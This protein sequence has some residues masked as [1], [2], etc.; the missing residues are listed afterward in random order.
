MQK[1]CIFFLQVTDVEL[2]AIGGYYKEN[3][4][5][6]F[7]GLATLKRD[8]G[9]MDSR[10]TEDKNEIDPQRQRSGFMTAQIPWPWISCT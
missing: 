7:P 8:K 9:G 10:W 2:R 4:A 6:V 1:K 3:N 5:K